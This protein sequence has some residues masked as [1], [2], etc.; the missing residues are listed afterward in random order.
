[1]PVAQVAYGEGRLPLPLDPALAEWH[2][3]RPASEPAA[4]DPHALFNA[5]VREPAG[6]APLRALAKPGARVCIVTSD[7]TRPVPNRQLI[8]W[9]LEELGVP[10]DRVTVL[11]GN[12]THR[13]NTPG[14][15]AGMFGED[16]ARRLTII[17]HDAFDPACHADLGTTDSGTPVHL[18]RAYVE[19]D[20]RIVLG[21]IEPH[22]F[23][24]FSGG[25]KGVAPGVA[26]IETIRRLHA[27]DVIGDVHATWGELDRNPLQRLLGEVV[28]ACP[29]HFLVNVTLNQEKAITRV[30]AGDYVAAHRTGCEHVRAQ[31]MQAVPQ[32]FPVVVTSNSGYP[33]DQNLYQTV[34]GMSAAAR[35]VAEGGTVVTASECRDGIPEH[36]RFGR[37][38]AELS[39]P[40]DAEAWVRRQP[41]TQ[42]DQWQ[43]QVFAGITG[44]CR[45][46]LYSQLPE[47]VARSCW[48]EP[49]PEWEAGVRAVIEAAGRGAP[50]AVLPEGPLTIPYVA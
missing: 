37:M 4:P 3:I 13:A 25:A 6:A 48:V 22:F 23:A 34:K 15:I 1:M 36:G 27:H 49:L 18:N 39:G 50:A 16:L 26:G 30:F 2:V 9:V 10:E 44:R 19:A 14:E 21:F 24:G 12:G 31:A 40:E 41:E 32:A 46:A 43:V 42:L 5:A 7:G 11:L 45:V 28:A 33:L 29:P 8:P 47:Q 20:L 17:N 35:I 38:L